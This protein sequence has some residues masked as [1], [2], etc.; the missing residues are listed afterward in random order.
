MR[1]TLGP[2][3]TARTVVRSVAVLLAALAIGGC[4]S[5]AGGEA[6]EQYKGTLE[7][8]DH[9]CIVLHSGDIIFPFV[10]PGSDGLAPPDGVVDLPDGQRVKVGDSITTNGVS[11]KLSTRPDGKDIAER[12]G[13]DPAMDVAEPTR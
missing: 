13:Y 2:T 1:L 5:L 11:R 4:R 12:C 8:N 7:V 3:G 10:L 9:G 6:C